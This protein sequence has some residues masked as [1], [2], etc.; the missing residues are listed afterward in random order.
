MHEARPDLGLDL[1]SVENLHETIIK[2]KKNTPM[3]VAS[4][5]GALLTM[6]KIKTCFFVFNNNN[7]ISSKLSTAKLISCCVIYLNTL[8]PHILRSGRETA[9]NTYEFSLASI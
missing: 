5:A 8:L 7:A 6:C 3:G 9:T 2:K 4:S 1:L